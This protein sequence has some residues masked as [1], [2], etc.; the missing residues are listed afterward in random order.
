MSTQPVKDF[1]DGISRRGLPPAPDRRVSA[2]PWLLATIVLLVIVVFGQLSYPKLRH[3]SANEHRVI[4]ILVQNVAESQ[5]IDT[6][7]VWRDLSAALG[8]GSTNHMRG[9]HYEPATMYLITKIE[10]GARE[11]RR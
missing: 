3:L 2:F 4:S 10:G 7:V 9:R 11:P 6:R 1:I 8:V 5:D